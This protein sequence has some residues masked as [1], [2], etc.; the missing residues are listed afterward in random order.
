MAEEKIVYPYTESKVAL[1]FHSAASSLDLRAH[2]ERRL[3]LE[4]SAKHLKTKFGEKVAYVSFS[5]S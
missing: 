5:T 4:S 3:S 2:P 1:P